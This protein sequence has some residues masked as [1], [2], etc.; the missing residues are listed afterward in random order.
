MCIMLY[1]ICSLTLTWTKFMW[2]HVKT[3]ISRHHSHNLWC[4]KSEWSL[5]VCMSN[6][7]FLLS[8]RETQS[9][10]WKTCNGNSI[11]TYYGEW[12]KSNIQ[13]YYLLYSDRKSGNLTWWKCSGRQ[14]LNMKTI[15]LTGSV[16]EL[17][18]GNAGVL[19]FLICMLVSRLYSLCENSSSCMLRI[20]ALFFLNVI[21]IKKFIETEAWSESVIIY[22]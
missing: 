18:F 11:H 21:C 10:I 20:C 13:Q 6:V 3:Q 15:L 2:A 17:S 5:R 19:D 14:S 7:L 16:H 22:N 4:S 8:F 9:Y 1:N 12:S